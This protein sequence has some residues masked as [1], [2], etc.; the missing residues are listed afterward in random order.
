[1]PMPSKSTAETTEVVADPALD[2]RR[3]R[4]FPAEYKRRILAE[5]AALTDHGQ[6]AA[7]LRREGLYSS[8]LSQWGQ[9]LK[10][11]GEA[12]LVPRKAGRKPKYDDKDR[13]IAKLEREKAKLERE[14]D[15]SHK[16]VALQKKAQ[17]LLA[18]IAA[19]DDA[20]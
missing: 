5:A 13:R 8:H 19:K 4:A 20:P 1:M 16:L 6:R 2:R 17:E 3:R 15:I 10:A 11:H 12:G 18:A 7:L 9:Q 14:L